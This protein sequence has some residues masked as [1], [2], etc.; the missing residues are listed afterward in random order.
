[1]NTIA[2]P[3][4]IQLT[5]AE[6]ELYR[7]ACSDEDDLRPGDGD[8]GDA[9]SRLIESLEHRN[10]IPDVRLAYFTDPELN[11]G[12]HGRSR[13]EVF[14]RNGCR[15][16]AILEHPHFIPYLRYF[17]EGP[18]L[19][20]PTVE[21]FVRIVREDRGTSGEVMSQLQRYARAEARRLGEHYDVAE[22]LFKLALECGAERF[23]AAIRSA[24]MSAR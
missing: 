2:V 19:P 8:P 13:R 11:I 3:P 18:Q 10:V 7:I 6:A 15:G 21:G 14:E 16:R 24:A 1:M 22:E 4:P 23:A 5:R 17:I 9:A 12:G 20:T